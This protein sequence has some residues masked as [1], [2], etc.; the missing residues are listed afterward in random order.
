[1]LGCDHFTRAPHARL[2]IARAS[3][4]NDWKNAQLSIMFLINYHTS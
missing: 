4:P 2:N 3:Q 1:M